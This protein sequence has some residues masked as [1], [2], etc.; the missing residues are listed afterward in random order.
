MADLKTKATSESVDVFLRR[1]TDDARRQEC[2][3]LLRIMKR[4]TG[5]DPKMWGASIVGLG[6]YHYRYDSGREGDWFLTGFS[7]RKQNLTLYIMAGLEN[8]TPLLRKLGKHKTGKCCL[9][10]KR[11]SDVDLEVLEELIRQSITDMKSSRA[12]AGS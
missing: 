5:A 2:L 6:S 3:T 11:I 1:A 8:Y 10:L 4:A 12:S 7:P 9:Y